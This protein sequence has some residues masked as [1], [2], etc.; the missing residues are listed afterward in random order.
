MFGAATLCTALNHIMSRAFNVVSRTPSQP[1]LFPYHYAKTHPAKV[2]SLTRSWNFLDRTGLKSVNIASANVPSFMSQKPLKRPGS[3]P[4]DVI[5]TVLRGNS[6]SQTLNTHFCIQLNKTRLRG[7]R[8][9]YFM[10]SRDSLGLKMLKAR[11]GKS[12]KSTMKSMPDTCTFS[13]R[14]AF[15]MTMNQ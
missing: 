4:C 13:S 7:W 10:T 5:N 8:T 1:H 9:W 3:L 12:E 11:I 15:I 14:S 6:R 2:I